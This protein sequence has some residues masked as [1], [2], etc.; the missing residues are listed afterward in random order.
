MST[1]TGGPAG[2]GPGGGAGTSPRLNDR[3]MARIDQAVDAVLSVRNADAYTSLVDTFTA[4]Q[5]RRGFGPDQLD[6]NGY[7]L[8]ATTQEV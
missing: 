8:V 2:G 1:N 3:A 4:A 7:L 6:R 5:I